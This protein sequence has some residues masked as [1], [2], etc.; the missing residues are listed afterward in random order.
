MYEVLLAPKVLLENQRTM[1]D[2]SRDNPLDHIQ[3]TQIRA[4]N[5]L[6]GVFGRIWAHLSAPNMFKWG[7]PEM[8]LRW[9]GG[10]SSSKERRH[11]WEKRIF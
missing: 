11:M 4:P 10:G 6:L 7:I 5:T 9:G 3:R 1:Q 2:L 8:I